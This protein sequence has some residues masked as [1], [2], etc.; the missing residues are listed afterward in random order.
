MLIF[1]EG[2]DATGKDT[3]AALLKTYFE[4][5]GKEVVHYSESGTESTDP[6]VQGI[7]NLNYKQDFGLDKKTRVLLYL[8]NRYEQWKRYAEPALRAGKIVII[9]RSW[10]STLIYEGY[11]TGVSK[12]FIARIHKELLPKEYFTPDKYV[13]FTLSDAERQKRL[14]SQGKRSAEFFKSK[15]AEFQK[16]L[17]EAYLKVA[18]EYQVP[19]LDA[20]GT[21]E[22]VFEKLKKL[23]QI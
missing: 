1:V 17:N 2:Q 19:T 4:Q 10:F 5:Q 20:T 18:K 9:T 6:F 3:Q 16:K 7:A 21:P 15:D 8:V 22:E 12:S 11:G 14:I 23:F 13:I